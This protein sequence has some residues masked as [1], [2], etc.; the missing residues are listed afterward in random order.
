MESANDE[1]ISYGRDQPNMSDLHLMLLL[2]YSLE[3]V[4]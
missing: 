4:F 3:N 1:H 2:I